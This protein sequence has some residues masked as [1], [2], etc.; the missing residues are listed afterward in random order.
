MAGETIDLGSFEFDMSAIE[1]QIVENKRK[2][3]VY[4]QAVQFNQ[5][6]L[7]EQQKQL[8]QVAGEL[9]IGAQLQDE[10][11]E[12]YAL[13]TI[14]AEEFS[15]QTEALEADMQMLQE[16]CQEY[17]D[18]QG[19]M[20]RQNHEISESMRDLQQENRNLSTLMRG[21]VEDVR[22]NETAYSDLNRQLN[23]LKLEAKNLGAEMVVMERNGETNTDAYR[24]LKE[25]WER[26][27]KE[28]DELNDAFKR[29]DSAVGDNQRNVG[30]YK[31]S[32]TEA[33][34]D[35]QGGFE[36]A[37]SGDI[38][39]SM[40]ML[41]GGL[42]KVK[43]GVSGL[44]KVLMANPILAV[45][46]GL[47]YALKS[48][49]DFNQEIYET[50]KKIEQ[51]TGNMP[52]L[53]NEL[54][55]LGGTI[56]ETFGVD[57]FEAVEQMDMLIKTFGLSSKEA[58]DMYS[59]G[60]LRGGA[61]NE[62]FND[63]ISEYSIQ[64]QKAGYS[65]QDMINILNSGI[66]LKLYKDKLPDAVK[67]ATLSLTEQT[68]ATRDALTNAFGASFTD[69]ILRKISAG[70]ITVAQG[71]DEISKKAE[72]A[73]L[74]QQQLA[75]LTADV[76]K[77]AGEDAGGVQVIMSALA[78]A[79]ELHNKKLTETQQ[80]T[81]D[82]LDLNEEY[83]RALDDAFNVGIVDEFSKGLKRFWVETKLQVV[84]NFRFLAYAL[85][86]VMNKARSGVT[87]VG[88]AINKIP[89]TW[90]ALL[91]AMRKDL[92]LVGG[93]FTE[94]GNV[95]KS[96]I[97]G[98]IEGAREAYGRMKNVISD[99]GT[100]TKKVFSDSANQIRTDFADAMKGHIARQK[101]SADLAKAE[102]DAIKR[103]ADARSKAGNGDLTGDGKAEAEKAKKDAENAEKKRL[104]DIEKARKEKEK[105]LAEAS[106]R[107]LD[108]LQRNADNEAEVAKQ[109]LA[110]YISDNAKKYADDKRITQAKLDDQK[111][112]YD[113]Q[114][115][116]AKEANEKELNA[117]LASLEAS[118]RAEGI[119]ADQIQSIRDNMANLRAETD[120]K[121]IEAEKT[122]DE[123]KIKLA[124]ER[125]D[126]INEIERTARA[127]GFQNKII[128]ME[129]NH[130]S[131]MSIRQIQLQAETSA[132]LD[133]LRK[134]FDLKNEAD[135]ENYDLLA[136]IAVSRK[137]L[138]AEIQATDDEAEKA[139]LESQL[140]ELGNI[141]AKH[142]KTQIELDKA[143]Q[144][145]KLAGLQG[146]LGQAKGLFKE[147]TLAYKAM[148]IGEAT[149]ST[150]LS[151]TKALAEVPYP[152]NYVVMGV[153]IASGLAQVAK[154]AGTK[155]EFYTGGYTGAGG[156]YDYAGNVHKGEVVFSQED[157]SR[158]GG[159]NAV[160]TFRKTGNT[161][162]LSN[163]LPSYDGVTGMLQNEYNASLTG[164]T[165]STTTVTLDPT[166][167]EAL[168][169]AV[170]TGSQQGIADANINQAVER[171]AIF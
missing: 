98:N 7:R 143:V 65:A 10:L 32:I 27:S 105:E 120:A 166:A 167:V 118:T 135:Q 153:N 22:G 31:E 113:E 4:S 55:L 78:D 41:E 148:A 101:E 137:E 69:D 2:L 25:E 72:T 52:A 129:S 122:A 93:A 37:F 23:A 70:K 90:N 16:R 42:D 142:A 36:S 99:F 147:N 123:A 34:G 51:L 74:N 1:K 8:Q 84:N 110:N 168:T 155:S 145:A 75:Q 134:K 159:P 3:D 12:A 17:A 53:V 35:L 28:A 20:I 141:E 126:Q 39:G 169:G 163:L 60:L 6:I 92:N 160:D 138:E 71:L 9:A 15:S 14:S 66:D 76:F 111:K 89:E 44:F 61:M 97:T 151:A 67:E 73:N 171:G 115:R 112:F 62:E 33:F 158:L 149:I 49:Y 40:E 96:G 58:F 102:A 77:G 24:A 63:S 56:E 38:L 125:E 64:F 68:K 82:L 116:L 132:E 18:V 88:N 144:D 146:A 43:A 95:I 57:K 59:D 130:E 108:A 162:I 104:S 106:K 131:E 46:A 107:E 124:K 119:T 164:S 157:V 103:G 86:D 109:A 81:K 26:V 5:R 140:A 91:Q 79:Q 11:N 50:N 87:A 161:S 13:G 48:L 85:T 152:M 121:N 21:G 156:K 45:V 80:Y 127:I 150:Y 117:K 114:A 154:I 83:E 133:E 30:N 29:I 94:L 165:V 100:N 19:E 139:R 136:E 128:E 170:Y 47:L 54:R